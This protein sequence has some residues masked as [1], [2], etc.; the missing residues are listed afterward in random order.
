MR[1][2]SGGGGMGGQRCYQVSVVPELLTWGLPYPGAAWCSILQRPWLMAWSRAAEGQCQ[3]QE[4]SGLTAESARPLTSLKG[5]GK[6]GP[7][8]SHVTASVT[9]P[10]FGVYH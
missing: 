6:G 7:L 9:V 8:P 3:V 10:G 2:V 1:T 5:K 4:P